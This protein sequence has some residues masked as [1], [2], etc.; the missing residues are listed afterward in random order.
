MHQTRLP[1]VYLIE[2]RVFA[3]R[4]GFF[5]ETW[6]ADRYRQA[7]IPGPFVQDNASYSERGVL[8]GLHYQLQKPQGKLVSV[9][10]GDVFDVAVDIRQ[11][12]PTFGQWVG[13][14]LSDKNH[15]Q[16][17]VPPGFAHGFCVLSEMALFCYKCTDFYAP[18]DE[19][20]VCWD[21]P[22]LGIDWPLSAPVLSE[23]DG[24]YPTLETI[25]PEQLPQFE[26]VP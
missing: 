18:E 22:A 24:Q 11:G 16:L 20:G 21:D 2:P 14:V 17:Y 15:R 26:V 9:L 3:D 10:Q 8:R 4:R 6:Q 25:A 7:Q 12:S 19:Y 1:G 23:R 13:E 5:L